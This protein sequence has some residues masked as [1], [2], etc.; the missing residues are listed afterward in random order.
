MVCMVADCAGV[1]ERHMPECPNHGKKLD[2][3]KTRYGPRFYCPEPGCTVVWWPG[4][5]STPADAETRALRMECHRIFDA[6]WKDESGPWAREGKGIG[7]RRG[8]GYKWM[9]DALGLVQKKTHI[10]M[11]DA[12]Q[13]KRLLESLKGLTDEREQSTGK[14]EP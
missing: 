13:C 11:F 7:W 1:E 4:P 3:S 9:R 10:G 2:W 12:E 5:T 8:R 14:L 6:L